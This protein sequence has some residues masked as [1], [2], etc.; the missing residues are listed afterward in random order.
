MLGVI[1][2]E[3]ID[4]T[5]VLCS[6]LLE[7]AMKRCA[8]DYSMDDIKDGLEKGHYLLWAWADNMKI[9]CCAVTSFIIYP[10]NKICSVMMIGGGGLKTWKGIA[11]DTIAEWAKRNGCSDL[12]GYD[13]R[14]WLRILPNWRPLWT[15][16]RRKL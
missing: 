6:P 13:T 8:G 3:D 10:R 11:V 7:K 16:I 9:V 12:E 15:V 2:R 5:W 4:R 14:C 1:K